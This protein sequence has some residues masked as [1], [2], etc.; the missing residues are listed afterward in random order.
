MDLNKRRRE[1]TLG[2]TPGPSLSDSVVL[3]F[4]L[5]LAV[6]LLGA[7]LG[8]QNLVRL[9]GNR[10]GVAHTHAVEEALSTLLSKIQAAE[11]G[12]RDVAEDPRSLQT[13]EASLSQVFGELDH[14]ARLTSDNADQQARL[15]ALEGQVQVRLDE[16][17]PTVAVI[18]QGDRESALTVAES[19]LGQAFMND[20]RVRIAVMQEAEN[21]L[22]EL[23]EVEAANSYR[24]ALLSTWL[25]TLV[26]VAL[27]TTLFLSFRRNSVQR[28]RAALILSAQKEHLR[29]TLES[30]GDGVISTDAN[31]GVTYLNKVAES[32]T[33]WT[34]DAAAGLP[35]TQ[36]FHI[37]DETTREPVANPALRAL[38]E[39]V[40]VVPANHTVLIAKDGLERPID[41]NA[42]P[43]RCAD[44]ELVGCVLVFRDVTERKREA[45]AEAERTRLVSLRC[46]VGSTLASIQPTPMA[47]QH[48]CEALV[49]H[50]DA[51]LARIWTLNDTG[52][53]LEL[54]AS[55]GPCTNLDRRYSRVPV[56]QYKI[57][58]IAS[59][60]QPHLTNGVLENS[61][62]SARKW[63]AK[64]GLVAFAGYPLVLEDRVVGVVAIF[65]R[66]PLTEGELMEL[67][68]LAE[69][70]A[71]FIDRRDAEAGREAIQRQ[72]T[73][74]LE[75]MTDGFFTLDDDWRFTYVNPV[76]H[77]M[78]ARK[79]HTLIGKKLWDGF[80]GVANTEFEA[81][82]RRAASKR[83]PESYTG[84]YPDHDRWYEA[85]VF[86]TAV[87]LSVY[88]RDVSVSARSQE[89]LKQSEAF[90]R[91]IFESSPD[92]VKVLDA[93]G[94][95]LRMNA[96]G[97]C[98]LELDD[99]A[100]L[101]GQ[102]W[103]DMWPAEGRDVVVA[104]LAA[105]R[106]S[107]KARFQGSCPTAL[108]TEKWWDV[109]VAPIREEAGSV[110]RF[111]CVSRDITEQRAT[112]E[113]LRLVAA[114]LSEADHRKDEF[115]ATLAHE[116]RNPLA[117]I[118]NG[119]QILR[120]LI[121]D[122]GEVA[123]ARAMMERQLGHMVHLVDDLLDVSRIS[124]GTLELRRRPLDLAEA[125][126]LALDTNRPLI[127]ARGQ[128]LTVTLPSAPSLVHGDVTRLAQVFGNLLNNAAK[129]SARGSRIRLSAE[130]RGSDIVVSVADTG[131]GIPRDILP[132]VFDMFM[133]VDRSLEKS[134]GGLGIGL[135]LVKR[136]VELHGGSVE[137][138]SEGLGRGSEF[139]V[140][141]PLLATTRVLNS[142]PEVLEPTRS[143]ATRKILVA[144]DNQDSA[145]S[146]ATILTILGNEVRTVN[147]GSE[148]VDV[149]RDFAPDVI[150][151]DIG[152]PKVN[153]YEAC[154][155]IRAQSRGEKTVLIALTGWGQDEDRRRSKA[156][157]FDHHLVK[158]VD[159]AAL[160]LLLAGLQPN[161]VG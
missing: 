120:L 27:V 35:L 23:R 160:E 34:N 31:G 136:L 16:L 83:G 48:T 81:M 157:G 72:I 9:D 2:G 141:I 80:P 130:L 124:R 149:A 74:T 59:N 47:L 150:L 17:R 14:L 119:L 63:A 22:L 38:E 70:I 60:R 100:P 90:S 73:S 128:T 112:G 8:H 78:L 118:R 93:D 7:A 88:F 28:R 85:R 50:L 110:V 86:P 103:C 69:G 45:V 76:A 114:E 29:T 77:R 140:V 107:G 64:E 148:A 105:A 129:F 39:G 82:Y 126:S 26:G 87:G 19:D 12:P 18:R 10:K 152:M 91:G 13:Y 143:I 57:G 6:L 21:D 139:V 40:V 121:D 144:D 135:T 15:T 71:Q 97:L 24:L 117:P 147:D 54:Q 58:R 127:E 89:V 42:S 153:G 111:I 123:K 46:D 131:V 25:S 151:L 75:S 56:G 41:D 4:V 159:A 133:Q 51:A 36:V 95:F 33:G 37:V 99:F 132:R 104:A 49:H 137:A 66:H 3:G 32:L 106:T 146:L 116:L 68:P 55:A 155:R 145:E 61:E 113:K 92:C 20:V 115:L 30:I 158:P 161:L 65:A 138:R 125:L 156:A 62:V 154:R 1:R 44:G 108:G 11:A 52:S 102:P 142:T 94:R 101:A 67:A 84:Y 96:N 79:A 53:E 98:V 122:G 134:Q 43:I 109:Q 5:T